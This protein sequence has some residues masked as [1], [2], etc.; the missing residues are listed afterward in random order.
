MNKKK[1]QRSQRETRRRQHSQE[2]KDRRRQCFL[3]L[4][5]LTFDLFQDSSD[6]FY[7]MIIALNQVLLLT[8]LLTDIFYV[9]SGYLYRFWDIVRKKTDTQTNGVKWPLDSRRRG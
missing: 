5:T 7:W 3:W 1:M 6:S 2:C 8:Y 9:K 4:V